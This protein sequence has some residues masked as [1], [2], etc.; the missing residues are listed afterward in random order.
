MGKLSGTQRI[1]TDEDFENP[2]ILET[3]FEHGIVVH[4]RLLRPL[5]RQL[6]RALLYGAVALHV[7]VLRPLPGLLRG[8]CDVAVALANLLG[9]LLGA[10]AQEGRA[11]YSVVLHPTWRA[12]AAGSRCLYQQCL[13]PCGQAL[14]G[15]AL[16][17]YQQVFV[18]LGRFLSQSAVAF[19]G[20]VPGRGHVSIVEHADMEL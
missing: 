10:S 13:V 15:A 1:F 8:F 17:T 4:Y 7:Y 12:L 5:S 16:A 20:N 18:P 11:F 3:W 6:G 19:Y 9:D 2:L 14:V